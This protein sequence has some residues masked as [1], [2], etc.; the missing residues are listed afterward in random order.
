M[1]ETRH[2]LG[3]DRAVQ[4]AGEIV[5][6]NCAGVTHTELVWKP[7]S[8]RVTSKIRFERATK[9]ANAASD[10]PLVGH[11]ESQARP[12]RVAEGRGVDR[13]KVDGAR[14][15]TVELRARAVGR[16][17]RHGARCAEED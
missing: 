8:V 6:R 17:E 1:S 10:H 11:E 15:G 2:D 4:R 7:Q 12:Q 5:R 3:T 16:Y 13:C 9:S 14:V